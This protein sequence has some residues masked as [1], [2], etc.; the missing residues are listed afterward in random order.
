MKKKIYEFIDNSKEYVPLLSSEIVETF[1]NQ[2]ND[3]NI[4][5]NFI[6]EGE[7]KKVQT[8]EVNTS[9]VFDTESNTVLDKFKKSLFDTDLEDIKEGSKEE[10]VLMND[11]R[12][13]LLK[14]CKQLTEKYDDDLRE[15]FRKVVLGN[16]YKKDI[17]PL[18]TIEVVFIDIADYSSVPESCKYT[19]RIGKET[20]AEINTDEIIIFVQK[21]QEKTGMDVNNIVNIEKQA[22]NPLFKKVLSIE[23]A[24]KFLNEI[25]IYFFVDY[26]ISVTETPNKIPKA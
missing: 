12:D 24:R 17:V 5:Y 13:F 10:E 7:T 6:I 22:G 8:K 25:S 21:R 20:G 11:V 15:V 4:E 1:K 9:F 18:S 19:L 14:I 26:S 2:A 16:K 3:E 23:T